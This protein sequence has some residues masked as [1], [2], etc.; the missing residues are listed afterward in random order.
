M[1]G[2]REHSLQSN[3]PEVLEIHCE[4]DEQGGAELRVTFAVEINPEGLAAAFYMD[5]SASM[6]NSGNYGTRGVFARLGRQG[7]PV[8]DA[9]RV[10][11]PYVAGL[12]ADGSCRVAYWATGSGQE[13]EVVGDLSADTGAR[14]DFPGPRQ[15]GN[16]TYLLPAVRDFVGYVR[17]LIKNGENVQ[18]AFAIVVTDGQLHDLHEVIR[19]TQEQFAPAV[20][21]GKFPQVNITLV[22]VGREVDERQLEMLEHSARLPG[23]EEI[24]HAAMASQ[25]SQLPELVS[26]LVDAAKPAFF[27][28]ATV[29]DEGGNIL[30]T[31]EDMVPAVLDIRT[32]RPVRQITIRT[33]Q[34]EFKFDVPEDDD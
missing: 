14:A 19:Y 4:E 26:H 30:A 7:N 6:D 12:D 13:V 3:A 17:D 29:V 28:G 5:G 33:A 25:I 31:Y 34:G 32:E 22:G 11:V 15:F 9:M 21:D 8:Q 2:R 20:A 24:F 23:Q 18:R 10:I 1:S 16:G 27:G